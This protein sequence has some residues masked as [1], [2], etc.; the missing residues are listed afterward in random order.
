MT[1]KFHA[2]VFREED[3]FIAQCMELDVASEGDTPEDALSMLKEA[4]ELH[5]EPPLPDEQPEL[6]EI[7]IESRAA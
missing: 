6:Y 3:V 4:L 1:L 5:F 7:E 2:R